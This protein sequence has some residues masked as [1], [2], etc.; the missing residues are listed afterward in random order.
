MLNTENRQKYFSYLLTFSSEIWYEIVDG[1]AYPICKRP[2]TFQ[3]PRDRNIR[4]VNKNDI[5]RRNHEQNHSWLKSRP[6]RN[7]NGNAVDV[8]DAPLGRLQ[9]LLLRHFK[10]KETKPTFTP[11]TDTG[12][13]VT[14]SMLKS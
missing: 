2:G 9:Q 8:T 7:A 11:H 14:L 4:P 6:S 13:S 1:I 3:I 5:Y 12:D 10:W